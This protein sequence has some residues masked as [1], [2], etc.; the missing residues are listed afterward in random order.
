M[1]KADELLPDDFDFSTVEEPQMP[2]VVAAKPAL[3]YVY[4]EEDS[5]CVDI[6]EKV[7]AFCGKEFTEVPENPDGTPNPDHDPEDPTSPPNEGG[8]PVAQAEEGGEEEEEKPQPGDPDFVID[9][10]D[11]DKTGQIDPDVPGEK[12]PEGTGE[13][14]NP[15][16]D[17]LRQAYKNALQQNA[18]EKAEY[19]SNIWQAIR[20][21]SNVACWSDNAT[22]TFIVQVRQQTYSAKQVNACSRQCCRCDEDT[23]VIPLDYSPLYFDSNIEEPHHYDPE[24]DFAFVGGVISAIING[25]PEQ[26]KISSRYLNEHYDPYTQ[27]IYITRDDFPEILLSN[28]NECCCLCLRDVNITLYYNAGYETIPDA[29]LSLICP[30]L[31]RIEDAKLSPN[32]CAMAMTQVSGLLKSKKVG[33]VQYTWS[34]KDTEASKT[35]ALYTELF[36]IANIAELEAISRCAIVT[37][38][39]AGEVI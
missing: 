3:P 7:A 39:D 34:D 2:V 20:F 17:G 10:D 32:Q 14:S 18:I 22:D 15:D 23:I 38:I 13:E 11:P 26:V 35:Q 6:L 30:I 9:P 29:L 25:K 24:E 31:G 19:W 27:R 4:D 1:K 21:L 36:N 12:Y 8:V 28:R 33:D 5:R 16:L 37:A